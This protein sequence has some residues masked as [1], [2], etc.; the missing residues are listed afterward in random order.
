MNPTSMPV[1]ICQLVDRASSRSCRGTRL[2]DLIPHRLYYIINNT[3]YYLLK[4][5]KLY[6]QS[7]YSFTKPDK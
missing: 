1:P 6:K 3:F 7:L 5:L 4:D 2:Q